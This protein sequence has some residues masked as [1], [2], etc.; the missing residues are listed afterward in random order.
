MLT[1]KNP[2]VAGNIEENYRIMVWALQRH[3]TQELENT[4]VS[5]VNTKLCVEFQS[6]SNWNIKNVNYILFVFKLEAK[7]IRHIQ[8]NLSNNSV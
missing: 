2:N 7:Y 1:Q 8:I 3:Y 6:T 4:V 5:E